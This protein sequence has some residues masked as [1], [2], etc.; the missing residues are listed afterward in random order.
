MKR[1]DATAIGVM[2]VVDGEGSLVATL[3]DGDVRRAILRG[4][5]LDAPVS[6]VAHAKPVSAPRSSTRED[7]VRLMRER[8]VRHVPLVD[9]NLRPI[10]ICVA[11]D[12]AVAT[13]NNIAVLM[14]GGRG[15]RLGDLTVDTPK[16]LIAVGGRPVLEILIE[17]LATEGFTH[18]IITVNY[19]AERV[20]RY[21][22]DGSKYG[23]HIEY[24]E[25]REALGTA[26]AL[27]I[28]GDRLSTTFLVLNADLLTTVSFG[29]LLDAHKAGRNALTLA[30]R[31]V[32]VTVRYGVVDVDGDRVT[33]VREKPMIHTRANAGMYVC[34]PEVLSV[35]PR[36]KCDMPE[37]VTAALGAGLRVGNYDVHQLW[38]DIGELSDLERA[39]TVYER[40]A[41]TQ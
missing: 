28:I 3:T 39:R 30:T 12:L 40:I 31:E 18:L 2:L 32:E 26:G 6:S 19:L 15:S 38:L 17:Q 11:V 1:L 8:G 9:P 34:E 21:F 37:V 29:D 20:Q 13:R 41:R 27:S 22:G 7:I 35:V 36:G 10:A 23:V 33:S 4:T 16:P 25:E 24:I 14:A 5:E